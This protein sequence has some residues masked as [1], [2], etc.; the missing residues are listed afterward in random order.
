MPVSTRADRPHVSWDDVRRA[1]N[2]ELRSAKPDSPSALARR[3][4]V[5]ST[6]LRNTFPEAARKLSALCRASKASERATAQ[7]DL[8]VLIREQIEDRSRAGRRV[9]LRASQAPVDARR[10]R[11][12]EAVVVRRPS[13]PPS[14][15][16]GRGSYARPP[17]PHAGEGWGE[18][19]RVPA[20]VLFLMSCVRL[21]QRQPTQRGCSRSVGA[22]PVE[23]LA[24]QA[25][26]LPKCSACPP[27]FKEFRIAAGAAI[28]WP[29]SRASG[30]AVPGKKQN[31]AEKIKSSFDRI[32]QSLGRLDTAVASQVGPELVRPA[33]IEPAPKPS[34]GPMIS[35]SPRS[36]RR[37]F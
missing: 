26:A 8:V 15:A 16:R 25:E 3:L 7:I 6:Q 29:F 21:A 35:T 34:E 23:E 17:L 5:D 18:G 30:C 12:N 2:A 14:P 22:V 1:T 24:W 31:L 11:R 13:P 32:G 33:G 9:S 20:K 19:S 10:S 4:G 36:P 28:N 37:A 27:R